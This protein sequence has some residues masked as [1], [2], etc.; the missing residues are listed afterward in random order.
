MKKF[1]QKFFL[2]SMGLMLSMG[3][4]AQSSDGIAHRYPEFTFTAIV[5]VKGTNETFTFTIPAWDAFVSTEEP[6]GTGM[7]YRLQLIENPTSTSGT[8][9]ARIVGSRAFSH[10]KSTVTGDYWFAS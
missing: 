1:T 9:R 3:A 4:S 6:T 5:S 7:G 2:L 8:W 10:E